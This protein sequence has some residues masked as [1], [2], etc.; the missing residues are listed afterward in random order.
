VLADSFPGL[1]AEGFSVTCDRARALAREDVQFLTWDHPLVTGAL[2]LVLGSEKGNS[3]FARWPDTQASGLYLEAVYVLES[4]APPHLHIDRFLPP[5]PLRVLIDQKGKET[6]TPP[7]LESGDAHSLLE[8]PLLRHE[9]V[10]ALMKRAEGVASGRAA[11]IA[12]HARKEMSSELEYEIQRLQELQKVNPSVRPEEINL[13]VE[14]RRA[15]DQG[16]QAARLRLDA[17]RLIERG[18]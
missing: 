1:S 17:I 3:S 2:D 12:A 16:L 11:E 9:V 13:L 7:L 6:P 5:T 8:N 15:L 10:P 18:P 4:I 14:Q